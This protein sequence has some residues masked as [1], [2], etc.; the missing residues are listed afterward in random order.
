MIL[1]Q[2]LETPPLLL[3]DDIFAELDSTRTTRLIELLPDYGQVFITAAKESDFGPCG[4]R[5]QKFSVQA[6]TVSPM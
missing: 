2:Q 3:L 6:G 4:D 1:W 5:F